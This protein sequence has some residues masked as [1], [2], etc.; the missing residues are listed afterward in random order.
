M[1]GHEAMAAA[2]AGEGVEVLFGV[3]GGSNDRMV[4]QL[5]HRHGVRFVAARHEQGAVGMAD[6]YS[7]ATGKIG[8][9]TVEK[10][11]GLTNTATA[12]TAARLSR[13]AVLL[14][15][16]DKVTGSRHGNMD[17]DQPPFIRAT[18]GALQQ[19]NGP[20]TLAEEVRLAFR[21]VRL[22]LGPM[23]LNVPTSVSLAEMPD[24]WSYETSS[25]ALPATQA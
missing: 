4:H 5:V 12:M 3:L 20:E 8:V 6:G 24:S 17:I 23:V 19:V 25:H 22:G 13:S 16:G 10:G 11:P 1:R 14:I 15:A 21:H 18:A 2:V 9:A 7:R